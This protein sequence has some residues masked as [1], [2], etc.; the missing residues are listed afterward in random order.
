GAVDAFAA[1]ASLRRVGQDVLDAKM[2]QSA[3]HLSESAA[4]GRLARIGSQ[5][6]P[7]GPIAIDRLR[8]PVLPYSASVNRACRTRLVASSTTTIRHCHW[9]GQRVSQR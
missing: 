5:S 4:I 1:T 7:A 9:S 3:A 6:G 8:D 2:I